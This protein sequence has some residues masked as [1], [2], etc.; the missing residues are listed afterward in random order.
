[1][2]IFSVDGPWSGRL[3]VCTRPR[4][5]GWL[6]DDIRS[7]RQ[8]GFDTLISAITA[9]ELVR[10][11]LQEVPEACARWG[12]E[13]IHFPVGNLQVPRLEVALP[14]IEYW[15]RLLEEGRGL[16]VHCW[17]SIGRSPTLAASMLVVGGV[18][19]VTAWERVEAA[20]GTQVPDTREQRLWVERLTTEHPAGQ[21]ASG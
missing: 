8:G 13:W 3:A 1:M 12:V 18:D 21:A 2:E 14:A 19:A 20:R 5:G 7:L 17:G 6:D 11:F 9:D 15:T 16:A 10:L 4:S